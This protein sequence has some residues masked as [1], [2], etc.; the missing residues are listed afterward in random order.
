MAT[1]AMER[2]KT[3]RKRDKKLKTLQHNDNTNDLQDNSLKKVNNINT[4]DIFKNKE[5]L[6]ELKSIHKTDK[7]IDLTEQICGLIKTENSQQTKIT[8]NENQRKI[9]DFHKEIIQESNLEPFKEN[10]NEKRKNL[11]DF[12]NEFTCLDQQNEKQFE[13]K[14][15]IIIQKK[16]INDEIQDL[17][18]YI[19]KLSHCEQNILQ[20]ENKDI[21]MNQYQDVKDQKDEKNCSQQEEQNKSCQFVKQINLDSE[22]CN[23]NNLQFS[24]NQ[25]E[26]IREDCQQDEQNPEEMIKQ[27]F[28]IIIQEQQINSQFKIMQQ[29]ILNCL[30]QNSYCLQKFVY[31]AE[32][33]DIFQGFQSL[34][35]SQM[36]QITFKF[37]Y[38]PDKKELSNYILLLSYFQAKN[39]IQILCYKQITDQIYMIALNFCSLNILQKLSK[40]HK[41]FQ[42]LLWNSNIFYQINSMKDLSPSFQK[43]RIQILTETTSKNCFLT[44]QTSKST[45]FDQFQGFTYIQGVVKYLNFKIIYDQD[46]YLRDQEVIE[47][48]YKN[49]VIEQIQ[50]Q[51]Q[52]CE[53]IYLIALSE[54]QFNQIEELKQRYQIRVFNKQKIL[55]KF[56][57][58]IK[59]FKRDK[60]DKIIKSLK[61]KNY[62]LCD[63]IGEGGFGFVCSGYKKISIGQYEDLA[64]KIQ[65]V[66]QDGDQE[67][68]ND[69]VKIISSFEYNI[70]VVKYLDSFQIESS[71]NVLIMQK[72]KYSLLQELN[73]VTCF[74]SFKFFKIVFD[75]IDGLIQLRM[76]NVLHLDIKPSNI[77]FSYN[78]DYLYCDFGISC[79][80]KRDIQVNIK[81]FSNGFSAYEVEHSE[82]SDNANKITF[83]SDI[84][85]L[86]KTFEKILPK[87]EQKNQIDKDV[88][89]KFKELIKENTAEN[90]EERLDCLELHN[91]AFNILLH[92]QNIKFYV[93]YIKSIDINL[94]ILAYDKNKDIPFVQEIIL[95][96]NEKK[97]ILLQ[98][99]YKEDFDQ[100]QES[101]QKRKTPF[102][103]EIAAK[104]LN[105][106]A[107][108]QFNVGKSQFNIGQY[109]NAIQSF[110]ESLLIRRMFVNE[111]LN[112]IAQTLDNIA[113]C[114]SLLGDYKKAILNFQESLVISKNI[115]KDQLQ[116]TGIYHRNIGYCY[117][118]LSKYKQANKN[119]FKSLQILR[120]IFHEDKNCY[121]ATTINDLGLYYLITG[122]IKNSLSNFEQALKIRQELFKE[123]HPDL[124]DSY[125]CFGF[126]HFQTE[127]LVQSLDYFQKSLEQFENI[128]QINHRQVAALHN[129]IGKI[130]LKL[131]QIN[132]AKNHFDKLENIISTIFKKDHPEAA[133]SL[134][135]IG[136]FQLYIGEIY[137]ALEK[138]NKSLDIQ[139]KIKIENQDPFSISINHECIGVCYEYLRDY[140]KQ[141]EYIQKSLDIKRKIFEKNINNP[142]IALSLNHLGLCYLNLKKFS[143]A[144]DYFEESLKMNRSIS[145]GKESLQIASNLNNLGICYL[146]LGETQKSFN[147]LNDSLEIRL[148]NHKTDHSEIAQSYCKIG[149]YY[150]KIGDNQ[151][152]L[153]LFDQSLKMNQRIFQKNHPNFVEILNNI[154]LC[155]LSQNNPMMAKNKFEES[156]KI[157]KEFFKESH[158]FI[159]EILENIDKCNKN[160]KDYI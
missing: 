144:I 97:N 136:L 81:G 28:Q 130:L 102:I 35:N 131:G 121:L 94:E 152:A 160:Q 9:L 76:Y 145:P 75:L 148:K 91:K 43:S 134:T 133:L 27:K 40:A 68:F 153:N 82:K 101:I 72:C 52:I 25:F 100:Y 77:L 44:L 141:L 11:V 112:E 113:Q 34:N 55:E 6:S 103:S 41:S 10:N 49:K 13:D 111:N 154:G 78:D 92:S 65:E 8:L 137:N 86:N 157:A 80:K 158:P 57:K 24:Q 114:W 59:K 1:I 46:E 118:N 120:S 63:I 117:L 15:L 2:D 95:Y 20:S 12:I 42:I 36:E 132:N 135:S 61:E 150:M 109:E 108:S 3:N 151:N 50:Y 56:S 31:S 93:S 53:S 127:N 104:S 90:N 32:K 98:K 138:F 119:L 155:H 30:I 26:Q 62:F 156:L 122:D 149:W 64:I 83:K 37:L 96:Y 38:L 128:Y 89:Q 84:Y 107:Q 159:A 146:N 54:N 45:F 73:Q 116:R 58:Q 143:Q 88:K 19:S 67:I 33:I 70:K 123:L 18:D 4:Y 51:Y 71:I 22:I 39:V 140:Q 87:I 66:K 115:Q 47:D 23:T 124:G 17:E 147:Y 60:I 79:I 110:Q 74:E 105:E 139:T 129:N 142:D 126:Y 48:L 69:E 7:K 14:Q 29:E 106:I 99:I 125:N 16:T 85:S 5:Q 21:K